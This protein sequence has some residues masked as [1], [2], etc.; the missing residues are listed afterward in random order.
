V[1]IQ[2]QISGDE[3][4]EANDKLFSILKRGSS[5]SDS[6]KA[7]FPGVNAMGETPVE[8]TKRGGNDGREG[9]LGGPKPTAV[10]ATGRFGGS[11]GAGMEQKTMGVKR[12]GSSRKMSGSGR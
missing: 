8:E 10:M 5:M 7:N 12:R 3:M 4:T 9:S 11:G 1:T 2:R 6:S